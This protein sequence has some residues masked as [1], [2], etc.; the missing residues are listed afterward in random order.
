[1]DP[2]SVVPLQ[3]CYLDQVIGIYLFVRPLSL[4]DGNSLGRMMDDQSFLDR[5]SDCSR[6]W[7][8]LTML[9]EA[10]EKLQV[11]IFPVE[12]LCLRVVAQYS[13]GAHL[14][15]HAAPNATLSDP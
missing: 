6:H 1:M 4:I 7:E 9:A 15:P 8:T 2:Q 10:Q 3:L 11:D 12:Y 5:G 14:S 13:K